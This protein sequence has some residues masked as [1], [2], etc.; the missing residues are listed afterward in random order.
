MQRYLLNLTPSATLL[1][2]LPQTLP[3]VHTSHHSGP[4]STPVRTCTGL[5]SS[6]KPF[7]VLHPPYL[8]HL[9]HPLS[10]TQHTWSSHSLKRAGAST[11][12]GLASFQSATACDWNALQKTLKLDQFIARILRAAL[13]DI[14]LTPATVFLP[15]MPWLANFQECSVSTWLHFCRPELKVLCKKRWQRCDFFFYNITNDKIIT[16]REIHL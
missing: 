15:C 3:S 13:S 5:P 11:S 8:H 14:S 4:H 1:S 16:Q 2:G 6:T 10:V 7:S 12:I 9:L